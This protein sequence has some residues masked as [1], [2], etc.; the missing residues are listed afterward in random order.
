MND[1]QMLVDPSDGC[2]FLDSILTANGIFSFGRV[3]IRL[4]INLL[5]WLYGKYFRVD[6]IKRQAVVLVGRQIFSD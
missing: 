1:L 6:N 2:I 4:K 5:G 3:K